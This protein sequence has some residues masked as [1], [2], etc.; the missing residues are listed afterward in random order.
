MRAAESIADRFADGRHLG[1]PERVAST[2]RAISRIIDR[3]TKAA[4][5]ADA[6]ETLVNLYV[7][8]KGSQDSEFIR[9]ITPRQ[10]WAMT[11]KERKD[12][13]TWSAWDKA[14]KVLERHAK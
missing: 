13:P 3:E 9:C 1:P 8:N 7:A 6:L 5:L 11:K 10:P 2:R 4:Y 14:R 12:S